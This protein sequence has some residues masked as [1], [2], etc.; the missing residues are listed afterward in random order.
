MPSIDMIFYYNAGEAPPAQPKAGAML[1]IYNV[2]VGEVFKD[3]DGKPLTPMADCIVRIRTEQKFYLDI[4]T[5]K[6]EDDLEVQKSRV[7]PVYPG[8]FN[9]FEVKKGEKLRVRG[10]VAA[11]SG[12]PGAS[13]EYY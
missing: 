5:S 12:Q 11:T 2:A 9:D 1:F 4:F 10:L 6:G 13:A 8:E 7:W 3:P